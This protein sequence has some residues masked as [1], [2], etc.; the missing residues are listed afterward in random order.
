MTVVMYFTLTLGKNDVVTDLI[1]HEK[2][3]KHS[4]SY[5]LTVVIITLVN[6]TAVICG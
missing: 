4:N 5:P 2:L 3:G 1:I 6:R